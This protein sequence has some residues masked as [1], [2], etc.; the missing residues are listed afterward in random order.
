M[1]NKNYCSLCLVISGSLIL[2]LNVSWFLCHST[3]DLL[4]PGDISHVKDR[5]S[6]FPELAAVFNASKLL[7]ASIN[8]KNTFKMT[9]HCEPKTFF[10]L[11]VL[12][13]FKTVVEIGTILYNII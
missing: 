1:I 13:T 9:D 4:L 2:S 5:G 11:T 3:L 10:F 8:E 12:F 6:K 7:P